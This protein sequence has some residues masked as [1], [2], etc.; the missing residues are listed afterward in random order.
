[1]F[2]EEAEEGKKDVDAGYRDLDVDQI[3]K[4]LKSYEKVA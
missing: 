1:M 2:G 4:E 3:H